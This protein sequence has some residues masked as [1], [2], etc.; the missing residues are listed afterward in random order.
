MTMM[1][2]IDDDGGQMMTFIYLYMYGGD[3]GDD[4]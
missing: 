3:Y 1:T 4:R 2:M